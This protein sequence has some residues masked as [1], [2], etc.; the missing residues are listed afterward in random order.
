MI[1]KIIILFIL[2]FA[3][4]IAYQNGKN[5]GVVKN[6][7]LRQEN[8]QLV[9]PYTLKNNPYKN[10]LSPEYDT[11]IVEEPKFVN[12]PEIIKMDKPF[13]QAEFEK[14]L[15]KLPP[16]DKG[17][18]Y[19]EFD[20]DKDGKNEMIID[21]N[22]AMNHTPNIAMVVKNKKIIFEAKGASIMI[23]KIPGGNGFL[24]NETVD[25]NTGEIKTTRYLYKDSGFLPV[26]TQKSCW[27]NFK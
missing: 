23:D 8:N 3:V 9:C 19:R 18:N 6:E 26:F 5:N 24:L 11:R 13:N 2:I 17:W 14:D 25:W 27:I 15:Y 1:K 12:N 20:V 4:V 16:N 7:L 10:E 22:V 21:A